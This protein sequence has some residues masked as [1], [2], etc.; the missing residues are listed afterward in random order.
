M[1]NALP[2]DHKLHRSYPTRGRALVPRTT[3]PTAS[4]VPLG[5][6]ALAKLAWI[7]GFG[8]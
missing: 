6:G 4:V 3:Y 5:A 2:P 8:S 1:K 7:F